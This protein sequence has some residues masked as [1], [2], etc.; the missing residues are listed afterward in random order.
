[1]R[2]PRAFSV[3]WMGLIVGFAAVLT[4]PRV[5]AQP[6]ARDD[7]YSTAQDTAVTIADADGVLRN[8]SAGAGGSLAA[9][10][11]SNASNGLLLF[12]A[13]GGFYYLPDTGFAGNDTFAYQPRENGVIVGNVATVTISVV[14]PNWPPVAV[15]DA[16]ATNEGQALNVNAPNG[17]LAND[18]DADGNPLTAALVAGPSSGTLALSPNGSFG[19]TPA[20]GFAGPVAFTYQADDSTARSNT[21][22][23]TIT[24]NGAPVAQ[25]DSYT[26]S[27]DAPLAVA[28]PGVLG[29]DSDPEG[30]P[31]TAQV[32]GNV[33]NGVLQLSANGS[34]GFTPAAN[35]NGTTTFTYRA[36][37]GA[38]QSG[39]TTVT[40]AVSA[41]NDPPFATNAPTTTAT[42]GVTYRYTLAASDPD[43]TMPTIS[44]PTL[45]GW[46]AFT[47]PATISG[48]PGDA[49]VG[50]HAV[51]MSMTDGVAPAVP[52]QF[53][54]TV[55]DVDN[56]P[57]I[58]TIPE[59]TTTEGTPVDIDLARFVTDSDT[60]STALTFAAT[61]GVPP[62]LALSPAGRLSGTP[63]IGASAGT[64]TV[65][66]TV[67]D[68][69]NTVPGQL[70]LVVVPAGRVD[71][72]VT[73]SASPN[74]VTLETPTTWTLTVTNRAPQMQAP[75]ASLDVTFAGEVPFRFD[76]PP[77]ASGCTLT[78]NGD[79]NRLTCTL[80]ALAGGASTTITLTGR[81]SFAGDVFAEARV[82]VTGAA[83]D[84]TPGN[85]VGVASLSIA[86]SVAGLPAQRIAISGARAIAAGD[87][88][89][90]GFDDLA[91]ATASAQG[92]VV[93]TS[94]AD[95]TNP[96]RRT[97]ATPPQA[98]GGEALTNDLRIADL[99]RDNDLDIVTAAGNGAPNRAFVSA[100]GTFTSAPLGLAGVESRAVAVGDV[101]G[102]AFV[103]LVFAGPGTTTVLLNTGSGVTF[104][105]GGSVGP[106]DA[107]GVLLVN[108]LG[109]ALPE[110]VLANGDGGAAVYR[111][112]RGAFTL[113]AT[114]ATG[115]TS[116][117][118][119]GDF[120]S[121]GRLDLV[122]SR[123]AATLPAVPSSLV[124]LNTSSGQ[125]F[126]SDEL[127]AAVTTRLL[128]R[129]LDLDSGADVLALNG[130]GA[131]LF[132][133]TGAANGTLA[134][135]AQQL[136]TPGAR[137][138]AAGKFS[139]DDR[140]DLAV[141]GD[142]LGI[143]V[144]D[145]DGNFGE[146]DSNAPVIQLRG[147]ATVNIVIDSAYS[148]AGATATDRE[149]GDLTSRIVV[150]NPVD[151][152]LLGTY[153]VT[154]NVSDLS[155]NTAK[156]VT[157][158]VNVQPQA[159]ALEGGGGGAVGLEM[160]IALLL[161]A[162]FA[163]PR[164]RNARLLRSTSTPDGSQN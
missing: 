95:P 143:F 15:D 104:T 65:R 28:A 160:L 10:L 125:M 82:A 62:G 75:G 60:G 149:E 161:V 124:W 14:P 89:A 146:A 67:S 145:G 98:L 159:A 81:S 4:A 114:L 151:T 113:A 122:F 45:P 26:T 23:V 147:D 13:G 157:R 148:D 108:L 33:S 64:H 97:F 9:I 38:T 119:T 134:L 94:V 51:T 6:I 71:L 43:G 7:S 92:V 25:P 153:T 29:N 141:V 31:L 133:N 50:V 20:P 11:V 18:T 52:V 54:I 162:A 53:Q 57:S 55:E 47:A 76:A 158:T 144:N 35:F 59:Q 100:G 164:P 72:T 139:S 79:Q 37:D 2:T 135:H 78:P 8:D 44:A 74:P 106:H 40:I 129:D 88:D 136:A 46:L 63:Q 42:E 68:G 80:G 118:S 17:V 130:Y 49:D 56:P 116:A 121:D 137:G 86:Q 22:T 70:L 126:V 24:V 140:V 84:E 48:T 138:V 103:D 154:Y 112:T 90:D 73:M 91:V 110:L 142:S 155:G 109:D 156:P 163:M 34:F 127:G 69:A 99:D 107:R 58:A 120:N 39:P 128:V 36:G 77:P 27:E 41:V 5:L 87:L 150:A 123:D 111:N 131:R 19:F 115:P 96:G 1:M 66:F 83:L 105:P 132:T 101:N 93:F 21:A 85:D 152:K 16:Y 12:T 30:A 117:V 102:D 3:W 61:G 32:V